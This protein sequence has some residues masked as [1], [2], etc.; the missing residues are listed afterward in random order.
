[1]IIAAKNSNAAMVS[2][3]LKCKDID[4]DITDDMGFNCLNYAKDKLCY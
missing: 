2:T 3:L 4:V 1:L